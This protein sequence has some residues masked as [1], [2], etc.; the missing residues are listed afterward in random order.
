MPFIRHAQ[1]HDLLA[2]WVHRTL[3]D[4][5]PSGI[6][7]V[8][9]HAGRVLE[10]TEEEKANVPNTGVWIVTDERPELPEVKK[11]TLSEVQAASFPGRGR[12]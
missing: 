11:L 8:V 2:G 7:G 10:I 3:P 1:P 9:V 6:R 12:E 5:A 4:G